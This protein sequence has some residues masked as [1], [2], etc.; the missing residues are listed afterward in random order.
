MKIKLE[1]HGESFAG[2]LAGITGN[3]LLIIGVVVLIQCLYNRTM[4]A[5]MITGSILLMLAGVGLRQL[6][7]SI[8]AKKGVIG[9]GDNKPTPKGSIHKKATMKTTG[10]NNKKN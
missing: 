5:L 1:I 9:Y 2:T 8:F 10:R 7:A 6:A 3:C 4:L